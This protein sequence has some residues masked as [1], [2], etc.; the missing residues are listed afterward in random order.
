MKKFFAVLLAL[1][2][3][4]ALLSG[5][6]CE[7]ADTDLRADGSGTVEAKFGFS[8]ELVDALNMRTE[9]AQNGFSYFRYNN[10]GYYGDQASENFAVPTNSMPSLPT[11]PLRSPKR[12][13]LP[14][15]ARSRSPSPPT[16]D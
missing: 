4:A 10:R 7:V 6:M 2:M 12:A 14:R 3:L 1:T 16:A 5:C 13:L 11:S 15:P 9:M 8:E